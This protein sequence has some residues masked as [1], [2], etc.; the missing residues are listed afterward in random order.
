MHAPGGDR[1]HTCVRVQ[2]QGC[3]SAV[4]SM[5]PRSHC[6][7]SVAVACRCWCATASG[8]LAAALLQRR[9]HAHAAHPCMQHLGHT[10]PA[11]F[12]SPE[13][14]AW[15]GMHE[16]CHRHRRTQTRAQHAA[17]GKTARAGGSTHAPEC[18]ELGVM[19]LRP[20]SIYAPPSQAHPGP[21]ASCT[22][23]RKNSHFTAAAAVTANR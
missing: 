9:L 3:S 4:G 10:G 15:H 16:G 7:P 13:G 20:K 12:T 6:T 14:H 23:P 19:V 8:R 11:Q 22:A 21:H 5:R 18:I 1:V 2:Q 17:K